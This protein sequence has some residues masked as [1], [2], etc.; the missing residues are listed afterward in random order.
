MQI[1]NEDNKTQLGNMEDTLD[2]MMFGQTT[3]KKARIVNA[4]EKRKARRGGTR[5]Q[6]K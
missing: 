1:N 2:T 6:A 3:R 4:I 5:N